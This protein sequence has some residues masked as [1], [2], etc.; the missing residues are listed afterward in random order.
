MESQ[1]FKKESQQDR[2][3]ILLWLLHASQNLPE[4]QGESDEIE[5]GF[6]Q[7]GTL[8]LHNLKYPSDIS[9]RF[10]GI[11]SIDLPRL[12]AIQEI[13]NESPLQVQ[14]VMNGLVDYLNEQT[15]DKWIYVVEGNPLPQIVSGILINTKRVPVSIRES[16]M[17]TSQVPSLTEPYLIPLSFNNPTVRSVIAYPL[18]LD[19]HQITFLSAH[20]KRSLNGDTTNELNLKMVLQ[21]IGHLH[22]NVILAGDLNIL[23][24]RLDLLL[25]NRETNHLLQ[26]KQFKKSDTPTYWKDRM[27]TIDAIITIGA[28]WYMMEVTSA[29]LKQSGGDHPLL[30]ATAYIPRA[31]IQVNPGNPWYSR[32]QWN[33]VFMDP[34]NEAYNE[35][36]KVT[37]S[38]R[39]PESLTHYY[40]PSKKYQV[41]QP[42]TS[43]LT[44]AT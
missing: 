37:G 5:S 9:N 40:Q 41:K 1:I 42:R 32:S 36:N 14:N 8:N 3:M 29:N 20:F 16:K 34:G 24:Q 15:Q 35:N 2:L 39:K 38:K 10:N 18:L 23:P 7:V 33:R 4:L 22:S 12:L 13:I 17:V 21:V 6:V 27:A 26:H 25:Q 19:N 43:Y 11:Q 30:T 31:T 44:R 28:H